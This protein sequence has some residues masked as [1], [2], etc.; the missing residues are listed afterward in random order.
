[1]EESQL[2]D[3]AMKGL[4]PPKVVAH[5]R[6]PPAEHE[7]PHPEEDEFVSF[8]AFH[9]RG[10]RYSAHPFLLGLLNKW[11]VELQHLNPNGV[12]HIA[13][14][15]TLCEGFLMIDPHVNLLRVFFHAQG[16]SV[17][18]GPKLAPVRGFGL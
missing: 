6:A 2:K 4:L 5:W 1:M 9:E 7:E 13:G 10:L 14:F 8:L 12:L 11:K 18:G 15:V 16:L 3:F 17:K